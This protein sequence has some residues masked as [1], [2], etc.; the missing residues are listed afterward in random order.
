MMPSKYMHYGRLEASK[1]SESLQR[2]A[3]DTKLHDVN[4]RD[5]VKTLRYY[6]Q[7]LMSP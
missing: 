2:F 3:Q 7:R 5:Q 1:S 4:E 6:N